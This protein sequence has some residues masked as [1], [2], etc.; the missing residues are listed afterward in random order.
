MVH[1]EHESSK[2]GITMA[3]LYI[4]GQLV[5]NY[6]ETPMAIDGDNQAFEL[7]DH[8]LIEKRNCDR[9]ILDL[10]EDDTD[11]L[12]KILNIDV[13]KYINKKVRIFIQTMGNKDRRGR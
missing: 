7:P 2:K 8:L 5:E 6:S 11:A 12:G 10:D 9:F 13:D 3:E 1:G 4:N